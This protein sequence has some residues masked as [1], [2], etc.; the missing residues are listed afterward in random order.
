MNVQND[1]LMNE[2]TNIEN[3]N[4]LKCAEL[5]NVIKDLQNKIN[6][7][8]EEIN[9]IKNNLDKK[10]ILINK[11][12][13]EEKNSLCYLYETKL[14]DILNIA[15]NNQI[16]LLNII[17]E[18][19]RIIQNLLKENDN[20]NLDYNNL[21]NK[22]QKENEALKE[23]SKKTIHLAGSNIYNNFMNNISKKYIYNYNNNN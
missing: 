5:T 10:K 12:K 19:D 13:E 6:L 16:K 2:L 9:K 23:E 18:K 8:E 7:R 17:K 1:G 11:N 14:N 3:D 21:I 15:D 22:I 20:K 4:N